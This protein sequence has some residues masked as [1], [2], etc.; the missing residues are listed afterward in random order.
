MACCCLSGLAEA[1][2][3]EL[4]KA[5]QTGNE[6]LQQGQVRKALSEFEKAV[7]RSNNTAPLAYWGEA[8][9]HYALGEYKE[10][11]A[12]C[13][14]VIANNSS[15]QVQAI[16]HN[17][18]GAALV[19][20]SNK[21]NEK[22]LK[23]AE[24]E[25]RAA[26][27]QQDNLQTRVNLGLVL[28]YQNRV[29]E[30]IAELKQVQ[31]ARATPSSRIQ[32]LIEHPELAKLDLAPEFSAKTLDGNT[33]DIDS[34]QGKVVLLDFWATWCAPCRMTLPKLKK[35]YGK[36]SSQPVVFLSIS[37][38]QSEDQLRSFLENDKPL[39]AQIY[40]GDDNIRTMYAVRA[41]PTFIVVGPDG[42]I[43]YRTTGAEDV[44]IGE[45]KKQ[46]KVLE[47]STGHSAKAADGGK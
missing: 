2:D 1:A 43:R 8:R 41:Y 37:A 13:Q 31:S 42:V 14:E 16:V 28:I 33:V 7:K 21:K 44:P 20:E 23:L 47:G 40:D 26:L 9:A 5:I 27:Q 25:F 39:W 35:E 15:P 36:L 19:L 46:L 29:D 18:A 10:A 38:D 3:P 17:Y 6:M 11:A 12:A 30:G 32:R 34:L 22:L 4:E 24:Q 45:V